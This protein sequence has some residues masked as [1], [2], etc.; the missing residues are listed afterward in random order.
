MTDSDSSHCDQ[1]PLPREPHGFHVYCWRCLRH[2][3]LGVFAF[4][5]YLLMGWFIGTASI[6]FLQY[7][8]EDIAHSDFV[9]GNT[10][11]CVYLVSQLFGF[12]AVITEHEMMFIP[13]ALV[14]AMVYVANTTLFFAYIIIL[15]I[16]TLYPSRTIGVFCFDFFWFCLI[17]FV[18]NSLC[19][20]CVINLTT[21]FGKKRG[22]REEEEERLIERDEAVSSVNSDAPP[23]YTSL[24]HRPTSVCTPPPGYSQIKRIEKEKTSQRSHSKL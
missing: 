4:K 3:F 21:Y 23:S 13:Y 9:I 24:F 6:L 17:F 10:V 14:L 11:I 20:G 8:T 19:L 7:G 2:V 18:Y 5:C 15:I 22:R 12:I 1:S 16:F